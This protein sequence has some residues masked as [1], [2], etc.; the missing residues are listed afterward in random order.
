M[1]RRIVLAL[2]VLAGL[3]AC[4]SP[5]DKKL[6]K[7]N[8]AAVYKTKA[9]TGEE[10]MLLQGYILRIGVVG[11]LQG[12]NATTILDSSLTIRQAIAAQRKT[13]VEDSVKTATQ[14]NA[15]KE[16]I[17]RYDDETAKLRAIVVVTPMRKSFEEYEYQGHMRFQMEAVNS[18]TQAIVGFKGHMQ[19]SDLF[20]DLIS[21]LEIKEDTR[22]EPGARRV[23][24]TSYSYNQ[25]M[26]RDTKLRFT[27]FEKMKFEW[28]PEVILLADGTS[29]KV[30]EP[31]SE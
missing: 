11:V 19:V 31:P 25:F 16:A 15:R 22:M 8:V 5:A 7:D 21:N 6:T 26:D 9:L 14:E 2:G 23:F 4:A 18:G 17:K 30:P 28:K 20:G 24:N 27:D 3:A 29:I 1:R 13:Q 12:K 10:F